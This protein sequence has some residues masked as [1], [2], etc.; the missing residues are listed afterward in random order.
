[1]LCAQLGWDVVIFA[2]LLVCAFGTQFG[3]ALA[4]R[5]GNRRIKAIFFTSTFVLGIGLGLLKVYIQ[6]GHGILGLVLCIV[7]VIGMAI[8]IYWYQACRYY[9]R[10]SRRVRAIFTV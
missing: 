1:M 9:K 8:I 7:S 10:L 2:T 6:D 4:A 5:F 3:E